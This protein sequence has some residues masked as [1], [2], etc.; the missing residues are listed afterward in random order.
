MTAPDQLPIAHLR[1]ILCD[2]IHQISQ[3]DRQ[4]VLNYALS[5]LPGKKFHVAGDGCRLGLDASI[6]DE[7]I[8]GMYNLLQSKMVFFD[9]AEFKHD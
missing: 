1:R 6:P 8:R 3:S 4:L 9:A 2:Q 5:E 7:V